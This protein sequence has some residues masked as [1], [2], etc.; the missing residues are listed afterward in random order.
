MKGG[1]GL[2]AIHFA[3]SSFQN[4]KEYAN[5]LGRVWT[6]DKGGH[7]PRGTFTVNIRKPYHP[8][9]KGVA[10]FETYDELYAKL[11][12]DAEIEVLASAYSAFSGKVEPILFVKKYGE[13][14]VVHNLLGHGVRGRK[15]ENFQR[16]LVNGVEWAAR[17]EVAAKLRARCEGFASRVSLLAPYAPDPARWTEVLDG[18]AS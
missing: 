4:W 6:K 9:T 3:C 5:L 13:G 1:K 17:G 11:D 8:I 10:D 12:G 15:N 14:R 16:L 2:V 7:G 18:L